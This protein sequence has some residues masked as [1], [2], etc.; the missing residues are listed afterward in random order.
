MRFLTNQYKKRCKELFGKYGFINYRNYFYRVVND[1]FQSFELHKSAYGDKC[2]IHFCVRPL[3][4]GNSI[5]KNCCGPDHLKIFESNFT[6]F[7]YDRYN[8]EN[9]RKCLEEMIHYMQKYLLP[10]FERANDSETAYHCY[11]IFQ[12][13]HFKE[14]VVMSDPHLYYFALKAKMYDRALEHLQAQ[15]ARIQSIIEEE[16]VFGNYDR[17]ESL[18]ENIDEFD[19]HIKMIEGFNEK[20]IAEY[21]ETQEKIALHNLL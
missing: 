7:E 17:I 2:T 11:Y 5:A 21:I 15:K 1:V 9:I 4:E 19:K 14:G 8:E 6:W 20:E 10:Y 18:Q 13:E 12:E 16:R 3:C